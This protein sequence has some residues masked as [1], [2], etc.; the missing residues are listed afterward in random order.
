MWR[1]SYVSFIHFLG[2]LFWAFFD[3]C[4]RAVP[5]PDDLQRHFGGVDST[6][7]LLQR[8]QS[9][10]LI[11]N[12]SFSPASHPDPP[13]SAPAVAPGTRLLRQREPSFTRGPLTICT[14]VFI[15]ALHQRR[16]QGGK[17]WSV[18]RLI[19]AQNWIW[20]KMCSYTS[21]LSATIGKEVVIFV[22]PL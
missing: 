20:I 1:V 15:Q 6:R 10:L 13:W 16:M 22:V 14:T 4:G 19:Y 21:K 12:T 5:I 8:L 17:Y 9:S 11:I 18:F 2:G 3:W 7:L